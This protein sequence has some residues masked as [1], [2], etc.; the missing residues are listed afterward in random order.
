MSRG[1]IEQVSEAS[2][3]RENCA[4]GNVAP[5]VCDINQRASSAVV[6]YQQLLGTYSGSRALFFL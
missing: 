3:G 1:P 4:G 2:G 5:A 6:C